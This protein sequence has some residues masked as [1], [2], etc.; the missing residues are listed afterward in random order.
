MFDLV[1]SV[2]DYPSFLPWCPAARVT[3]CPGGVLASIDIRFRRIHQSFTTRNIH[4]RP[5]AI[6]MELVD[7]PFRR[8]HGRWSFEELGPSQCRIELVLDY[9]MAGGLVGRALQPV[10]GQIA[11]TFADAFV[12]R[13][14]AIR[15]TRTT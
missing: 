8:L 5:H 7:G 13:A 14:A 4:E 12:R 11:S 9:E 3:P 2:E 15:G 1:A 6:R 10:F